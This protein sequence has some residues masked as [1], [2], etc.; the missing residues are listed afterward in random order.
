MRTDRLHQLEQ[1]LIRRRSATLPEL[2]GQFGVSM[3]T[4]RRDIRELVESGR[5]AKVYGGVVLNQQDPTLPYTDRSQ[6]AVAEKQAIGRLAARL[7]ESGDTLYVDSGTTAVELIPHLAGLE[8]IT[9]VSNSL[10]VQNRI[11]QVPDLTLIA[12]GGQFSRRTLSCSG[13]GAIAG[14]RDLR[15]RKAFMSATG[16]GLETGATNYSPYEAEVKRTA[17]ERSREVILMADH[18]KFG[19]TA[20]ICFCP[21]DRLSA[22]VT[23]RKP[24]DAMVEF[25]RSHGIALLY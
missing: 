9:V 4:I 25:C 3:N 23:D 12:I 20:A 17:I 8:R 16:V 10:I 7:V 14:L 5:L 24:D 21:L 18:S 1:Y 6:S 13:P 22:L 2:C 15:I 19:K 11:L